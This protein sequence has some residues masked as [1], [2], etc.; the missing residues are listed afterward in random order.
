MLAALLFLAQLPGTTLLEARPDPALDMVDG[1]HAWL[2]ARTASAPARRGARPPRRGVLGELLGVVDARVPFTD[3][4]VYG[5]QVRWPVLAGVE[6]V[7]ERLSPAGAAPCAHIL[8]GGTAARNPHPECL[9]VAT[10][11]FDQ[12]TQ[13]SGN[14]AI[15]RVTNQPHREYV[16]RMAF[17]VGRHPLGYEAQKILSLVDWFTHEAPARPVYLTGVGDGA[18]A[19]LFACA[20]DERLA[21]CTIVNLRFDDARLAQN[22]LHQNLWR[23]AEEFDRERLLAM[24]APRAVR[25]VE[26]TDAGSAPMAEAELRAW[27]GYTQ[28]LVRQAEARRAAL[29]RA[30]TTGLTMEAARAKY[31]DELTGRFP[32]P[33]EAWTGRVAS[34]ERYDDAAFRGYEVKLPV[35]GR[36]FAYGHLLVPKDLRPGERRP[37]VVCQH[38]LEGRPEHTILKE[39]ERIV[40]DEFAAKLARAGYIVYAPQNPYIHG[41]RFRTLQRKANPL[42]LTLFSFIIAQHAQTLNWLETL[43]FVDGARI[44]FYGLS[45]GGKTAMHVPPV[46]PRY[47]VVICSGNFNEW[48]WKVTSPE[49]PFTY[50]FTREY[51]IFQWNMGLAFG[52]AEL[53]A[54][55]AP[56]PFMVERGHDDGV[57]VDEWV[58][59]E[60]AKVRRHYAKLGLAGR[61]AIEYFP[62][63]HR[64]WGVGTFEFLRQ[65]LG[66]PR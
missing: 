11:P 64:I 60:Y 47:K 19:A 3:F 23:F 42:G 4:G 59:Y 29:H 24:I 53:A 56:R 54:L 16:Y 8:L 25:F 50:L 6:A 44:G 35:A 22:P 27:I 34:R 66:A 37:V 48:L 63:G 38:G 12:L 45:Y 28:G 43:P 33:L 57:G 52:H 65:H 39:T 32:D 49:Q 2:D 21:D 31:W 62:G 46:E 40:C 30:L 20:L 55:I 10:A 7:G 14:P 17:E 1:L 9:T 15:G 41:E 18:L 36:I 58:S 5:A 13:F 61:T 26:Q 51:E